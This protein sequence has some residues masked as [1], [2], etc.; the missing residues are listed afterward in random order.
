MLLPVEHHKC[1]S[2]EWQCANKRCIPEAWQCDSVNDCGDDS[3]EDSSHCA[4]RTC[5]SGY[6]KCANG[7]CIPQT[8]KCDVDNDCGDYSDEPIHECSKCLWEGHGL[9]KGTKQGET[10]CGLREDVELPVSSLWD[11]LFGFLCS[12]WHCK[13]KNSQLCGLQVE[14]DSCF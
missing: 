14:P 11:T 4:S 10:L 6:F 13:T 2:N 5:H 8:W 9:T 7:R 12:L 1:E 3:D